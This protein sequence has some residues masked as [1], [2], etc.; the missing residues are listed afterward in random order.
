MGLPIHGDADQIVPYYHVL[1]AVE[2]FSASG[3][4][5]IELTTVSGGT[6]ESTGPVVSI[7]AIHW[8]ESLSGDS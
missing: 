4:T 5:D 6:H 3:V 1:N 7:N 2:S 8:I